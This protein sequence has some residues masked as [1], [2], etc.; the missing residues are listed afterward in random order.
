M[1]SHSDMPCRS[2]EN[3]HVIGDL[4]RKIEGMIKETSRKDNIM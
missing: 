1:P 3:F 4:D 2:H